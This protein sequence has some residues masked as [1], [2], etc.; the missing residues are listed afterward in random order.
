MGL[1]GWNPTLRV[2]PML[3]RRG[4]ATG[5]F[6]DGAPFAIEP[7][8]GTHP[9]SG[10]RANAGSKHFMVQVLPPNFCWRPLQTRPPGGRSGAAR[11]R[12]RAL[13]P[14]KKRCGD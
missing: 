5:S 7:I 6:A 8:G 12:I 3:V 4:K 14:G 10:G 11:R 13:I 1:V 9:T 2:V